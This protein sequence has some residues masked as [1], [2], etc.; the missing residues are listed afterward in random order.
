MEQ[1]LQSPA[2]PFEES[3]LAWSINDAWK[4]ATRAR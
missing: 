2:A 4:Y 1:A 3:V